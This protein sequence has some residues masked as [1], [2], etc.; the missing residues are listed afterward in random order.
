MLEFLVS[1]LL[2]SSSF[3]GVEKIPVD[4]GIWDIESVWTQV[5]NGWVLTASTSD[6]KKTCGAGESLIL[7]Q[8]IHGIHSIVADGRLVY[9]SGDDSFNTTSSFYE[10]GIVNCQYLSE[11]NKVTWQV[12]TYAHY[13][14][15]INSMPITAKSNNIFYFLD[16]I[17]NIAAAACLLTL[18][19]FSLLI[20]KGRVGNK[21]VFS[22]AIGSIAFAIYSAFTSGNYL[23]FT[24]SMLIIHKIADVSVWIGSFC[25]VFFFRNFKFLGKL[26]F[27]SFSGAFLLGVAIIIF[28]KSADVVQLGTTLPIPFAFVCLGSFLIHS[29]YHGFKNGFN[30]NIVLGIISLVS[31]VISSCNDLFHI[32]GIVDTYMFMPLGAVFGVFFLA[33]SVNQEIEKTYHQRDDLVANLQSKVVEQ[34]QHLSDA[35]EQL[36]KSQIDLVQSARLASLGTLSAGIAHE[37]NNAIN[38][39]NGAVL[40]L[41]RKVMKSIPE[42]ERVITEKLFG[43]IKE[44]TKLTVEIVRSLRNFTG[45]NQAKVKDVSL[46]DTINSVLT[47][48]KSKLSYIEV[49]IEIEPN[50][51][52]NCYQVGLNQIFMN[53]ISNSIDVLP[54]VNGKIFISAKT[55]NENFIEIKVAD[56][57]HGMSESVKNRIFDPF[58]TTKEVGKGT[59]LGLHI[60][61]KEVERHSGSIKVESV[62]NKGTAFVIYIP[63]N[64]E[65]NVIGEA[66]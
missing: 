10:R 25:Y 11:A 52:L 22:L 29:I 35:L 39:V 2:T 12:K 26:E 7:P 41:E 6:L 32:L 3:L 51:T 21:Y 27:Y 50:L 40:P 37:I 28:G 15:R 60:V 8:V 14:A 4:T 23:G 56:N 63:K 42:S 61:Q 47:I 9:Q 24:S 59:G 33:A 46:N 17:L 49:K 43:A 13:F 36:K 53:L 18:A 19:F 45:L 16:V 62:V 34:T 1:I 64:L 54:S 66:A 5:E 38:Y 48:L 55:L 58:F 31:F 65:G 57:G 20:F 44:G 30:K